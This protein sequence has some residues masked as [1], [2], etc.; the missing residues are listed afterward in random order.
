M[1]LFP[2]PRLQCR[3]NPYC[4]NEKPSIPGLTT[5]EATALV[6]DIFVTW[7]NIAK[8]RQEVESRYEATWGHGMPFR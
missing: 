8:L 7:R 1:C 3:N 4:Q 6:F 2:C 5:A